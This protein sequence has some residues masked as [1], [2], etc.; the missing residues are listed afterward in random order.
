MSLV[1]YLSRATLAPLVL[2]LPADITTSLH[3][4]GPRPI[5]DCNFERREFEGCDVHG[6]LS[7]KEARHAEVDGI[8]TIAVARSL[9][10]NPNVA[11][12]SVCPVSA[13]QGVAHAE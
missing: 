2:P 8:T 13:P 6:F 11:A 4:P 7:L 10:C 3:R 9:E 5:V 1:S 12:Y